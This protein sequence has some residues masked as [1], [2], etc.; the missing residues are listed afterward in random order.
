MDK[1]V[2]STI[3]TS[4]ESQRLSLGRVGLENALAQG[5][6]KRAQRTAKEK[7]SEGGEERSG[8]AHIYAYIYVCTKTSKILSKKLF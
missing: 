7:R 6:A 5:R 3:L 8:I 4:R 1:Q 2:P